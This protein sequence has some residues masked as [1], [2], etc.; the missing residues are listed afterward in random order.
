[1][2]ARHILVHLSG[3]F[4]LK[5]NILCFKGFSAPCMGVTTTV[6]VLRAYE[7]LN[8][9]II[10]SRR[11]GN[12]GNQTKVAGAELSGQAYETVAQSNCL[13]LCR[14]LVPEAI[15]TFLPF[16]IC[17]GG[18]IGGIAKLVILDVRERF[19]KTRELFFVER[20]RLGLAVILILGFEELER[21]KTA[22][23]GDILLLRDLEGELLNLLGLSHDIGRLIGIFV[24]L[25]V[26]VE[27]Q[28]F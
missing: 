27:A 19:L 11:C 3:D 14:T 8:R 18:S 23:A 28:E 26:E 1:M 16:E 9:L 20:D 22:I 4:A 12:Y 21:R 17:L 15:D 5:H 25:Y 13:I 7:G 6:N 24:E 2:N 10:S